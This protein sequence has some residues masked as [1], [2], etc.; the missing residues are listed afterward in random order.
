MNN[1]IKTDTYTVKVTAR[2]FHLWKES[3]PQLTH[4]DIELTERCNNNCIHCYINLPAN[5]HRALEK[6]TT[7]EGIKNILREA[8]SLGCLYVRFTGGEPL[9]RN[10]FKELYILARKLGLKVIIVTNAT[11]ITPSIV[12]LFLQFPPLEKIQI[13]V[14]GMKKSSYEAITRSTG[15]FAAAFRGINLLYRK[16]IPFVVRSVFLPPNISEIETF[17]S[18]AST[19][20][21]MEKP[22]SYSFLYNLRARRDSSKKNSEIKKLRLSPLHASEFFSTKPDEYIRVMKNFCSNF[23]GPP[24][25]NLFTCGA[26]IRSCCVDAYGNIQPCILIRH[27]QVVINLKEQ[28]MADSLTYFF[29]K[30]RHMKAQNPAYLSRCAIC[31]LK[32]LCHQCPARSWMEHGTLDS[33]VLYLCEVAHNQARYLGLLGKKENAWEVKDWPYRINNFLSGGTQS[34]N[35]SKSVPYNYQSKFSTP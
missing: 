4:L 11:L 16:N 8:V 7:T 17:E 3:R 1:N 19:I 26:G 13:T 24:G 32:G 10:D 6:E 15:S 29:P 33:P 18:W 22:P 23:I 25:K 2:D 14:Y 9:L 27:P 31:F 5:D 12:D 28:S 30:I 35:N 34:L 20:P 21:W